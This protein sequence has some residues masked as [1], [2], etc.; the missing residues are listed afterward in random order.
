MR[1]SIR[2]KFLIVMT[3]LLAVGLGVYLFMAIAV[4]KTDKTQLVFDLN[5]SQVANLTS[6]LETQFSGVSEKLKV[7]ALLPQEYQNRLIGDLISENSDVVA[8]ALHGLPAAG[9]TEL[10]KAGRI[11]H[12]DR[13]LETYGLTHEKFGEA[14]GKVPV[15]FKEILKNGDDIWNASLAEGPPLIGYGRL[16][17]QQDSRGIPVQQWII[18][19]YVKLDRLLKSVSLVRISELFVANQRGEVL[20]HPNAKYLIGRPSVADDSIL[21]EAL[22]AKTRISVI[23]RDLGNSNGVLAA[24]AK[25]FNDHIIVVAKASEGEV[26]KVVKDLSTRSM[27]FGSLVLTLVILAAFLLSRTLTHNIAVLAQRMGSAAR[28][29]LSTRIELRG[30]DETITL[31]NTFNKMISDLKESRDALEEVNRDL[32]QK[33]K[34]R[35]AELEV[36]NHKV[37]EAQE[38]LLRT[39]RLASVG[40]IAG[41][42]AHEVLNPLTILLTRIGLIQK[43]VTQE[44]TP[45]LTLF[46][47]IQQ[48]WVKEYTQGGFDMLAQNWK[49]ASTVLPG[50]SLLEEDLENLNRCSTELSEHEKNLLKDIQFVKEEG[51]RI[52]KIIN[53]M[54]RLGNT[55]S[56]IK[57]HSLHAILTDCCYIMADLFEQRGFKIERIFEASLDNCNTDRDEVIQSMTNLLRNSLHAMEDARNAKSSAK[58][59]VTLR[60]RN[61]NGMIVIDIEDNG[62]GISPENQKKLFESSFTTKSPDEGTGLGLGIARR[63]LRSHGGDIEFVSSKP[64]EQTIFRMRLPLAVNEQ[65]AV[66]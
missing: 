26:F 14:V 42:T 21:R 48:A 53:N 33:V 65:G 43:R 38:A 1:W 61:D 4:F 37:K 63:F 34:D 18:I 64:F 56:D 7:F 59:I 11:F 28:G 52:G 54:R 40:E 3:A 6:E 12:Q 20:V 35:T 22:S 66:A 15:P 62:V 55:K 32:D 29:D 46:Q 13:F 2:T 50:K 10:P 27:L 57:N 31:A 30:Q 49:A 45:S 58:H 9:A 51:E 19:G 41:R 5:R 25:G 17:V 60:T 44:A 24:F 16:V 39:T 8:I 36:Q 47:E 23:Q